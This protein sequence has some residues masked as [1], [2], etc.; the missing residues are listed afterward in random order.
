VSSWDVFWHKEL[1]DQEEPL[2]R[3]IISRACRLGRPEVYDRL[4]WKGTEVVMF[5]C[6][7]RSISLNLVSV[8]FLLKQRRI[9]RARAAAKY[10]GLRAYR[11]GNLVRHPAC[12]PTVG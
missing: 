11:V 7:D 6:E 10:G 8:T 9:V 2:S 5:G 12:L 4:V 3:V 1:A